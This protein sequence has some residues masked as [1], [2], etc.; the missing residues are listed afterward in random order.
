[1]DEVTYK[2]LYTSDQKLKWFGYG[3]WVEECDAAFFEHEGI[4][5]KVTRIV[6]E[7][8]PNRSHMF[9]GHFCGYCKIPE[10]HP[11]YNCEDIHS[12]GYEVH[13]GLTYSELEPNKEF[14]I[15]FDC[16]HSVDVV[17]SML[18]M[19]RKVREETMEM[20][21]GLGRKDHFTS[22]LFRDTYKNIKF[23][24]DQCK[25]LASQIQER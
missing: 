13:G 8:Y 6:I 21:K 7:E 22:I 14:W 24:E 15:G 23:A 9:G 17:P 10:D 25:L 12:L 16:A 11:D 19:K 2:H 3:E 1:M 4:E 20:L 18:E 5:C